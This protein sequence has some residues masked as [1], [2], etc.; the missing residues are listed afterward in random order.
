M[1]I[2]DRDYMREKNGTAP[3]P[4]RRRLKQ[5]QNQPKLIA[6]LRFF[7]WRLFNRR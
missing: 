5:A 2:A 6:R 7:C 1:G 4:K 3:A